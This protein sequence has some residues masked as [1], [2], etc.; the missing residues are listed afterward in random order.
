MG[1]GAQGVRTE[2][3]GI[4]WF[5]EPDY[6]QARDMMLDSDSLPDRFEHWLKEAE[7]TEQRVKA[8]GRKVARAIIDPFEFSIWCDD[9]GRQPDAAAREAFATWVASQQDG[10]Y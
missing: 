4:P 9:A 8:S 10:G 7:Q 1:D 2:A 5:L 3:V 6:E